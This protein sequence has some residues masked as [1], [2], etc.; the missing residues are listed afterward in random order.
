MQNGTDLASVEIKPRRI[1]KQ[2]PEFNPLGFQSAPE[3]V[4]PLLTPVLGCNCSGD[5]NLMW[6]SSSLFRPPDDRTALPN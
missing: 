2:G 4:F 1:V 5:Q 3:C 6:V